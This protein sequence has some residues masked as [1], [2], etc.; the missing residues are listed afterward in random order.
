VVWYPGIAFGR[1]RPAPGSATTYRQLRSPLSGALVMT[2]GAASIPSAGV[3]A[4]GDPVDPAQCLV[5][6]NEEQL[7]SDL[8]STS[9]LSG[10][11]NV[12]E[13]SWIIPDS[14][15][16]HVFLTRSILISIY[17]YVALCHASHRAC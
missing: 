4:D 16:D 13:V 3:N 12:L 17:F 11:V 7:T 8:A 1:Q 15:L 5:W 2:G 9:H 6:N 10:V 14:T